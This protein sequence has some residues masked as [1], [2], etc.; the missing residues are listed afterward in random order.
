MYALLIAMLLGLVGVGPQGELAPSTASQI[1]AAESGQVLLAKKRK[2][3]RKKRR[4]K[5]KKR[6]KKRKKKKRSK[7]KAAKKAAEA[8]AKAEAKADE[9]KEGEPKTDD[10]AAGAG[11][12]PATTA[13]AP[14]AAAPRSGM[15]KAI[16]YGGIGATLAGV[17]ATFGGK[18]MADSAVEERT[19]LQKR[20][21]WTAGQRE[22]FLALEGDASTGALVNTL[23]V[24]MAAV[25]ALAA[26][27]SFFIP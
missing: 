12:A 20:E 18:S 15:S 9:A 6:K 3:K 7:K 14:A 4:K 25:G 11:E 13:A 26:V 21:V 22:R 2:K 8:A 10:A 16:M 17:G 5:R 23:G 19:A 24:S 1:V 27:A